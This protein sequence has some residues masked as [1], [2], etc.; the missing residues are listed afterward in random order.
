M[1]DYLSDAAR[2]HYQRQARVLADLDED[3]IAP[4][5]IIGRMRRFLSEPVAGDS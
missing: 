5:N 1:A 2:E 4:S 3:T